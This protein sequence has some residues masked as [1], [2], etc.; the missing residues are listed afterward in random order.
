[1]VIPN[2][3]TNIRQLYIY[4]NSILPLNLTFLFAFG[5]GL[6]AFVGTIFL[7]NLSLDTLSVGVGCVVMIYIIFKLFVPSWHLV[8]QNSKIL[9]FPFGFLGGVLQGASGISAPI[10][11]TFLNSMKLTRETFISTISVFFMTMSFFQTPGLIYYKFL[12]YDIILI[13]LICTF[14]LLSSMPIGARMAK[15]I[16]VNAFDKIILILLAI[17]SCKIFVDI[18]LK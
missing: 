6:G 13:S 2:V 9:F 11:I 14:V 16:S 4:R 17:I 3:L 10:S 8:Y 1:M 7:V 5:G 15:S 12:N 18:L